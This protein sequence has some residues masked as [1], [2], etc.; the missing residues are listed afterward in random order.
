[1]LVAVSGGGS[2]VVT[3]ELDGAS[4][5]G[6]VAAESVAEGSGVLSDERTA[7]DVGSDVGGSVVDAG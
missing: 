1:M 6:G 4:V 3:P 7:P 2:L 5:S